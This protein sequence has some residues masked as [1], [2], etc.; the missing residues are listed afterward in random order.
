MRDKELSE[1]TAGSALSER[2]QAALS[3]R[4]L[5]KL[6]GRPDAQL[7]EVL[8]LYYFHGYSLKKIARKTGVKIH[9]LWTKPLS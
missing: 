2:E 6:R 9:K 5:R 8:N 4:K 3:I 1:N 7:D